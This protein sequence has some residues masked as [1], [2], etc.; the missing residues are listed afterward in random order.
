MIDTHV[1]CTRAQVYHGAI[2][3]AMLCHDDSGQCL[4]LLLEEDEHGGFQRAAD[5]GL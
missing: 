5:C 1:A 2:L 3:L 4:I